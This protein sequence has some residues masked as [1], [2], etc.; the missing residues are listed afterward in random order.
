M[1]FGVCLPQTQKQYDS[2]WLV[3][4]RLAKS[5]YFILVKSNFSVE[6]YAKIFLYEIYVAVLF[7]YPS[8]QIGVHNSHICFGRHS[9]KG[10]VPGR[11]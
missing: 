11:S 1:A 5:S 9:N 3:M 4:D 2:I 8:Y 7:C 6:D 10:W